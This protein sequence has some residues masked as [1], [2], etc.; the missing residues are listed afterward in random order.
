M[1]ATPRISVI[2][3]CYNEEEGILECHRRLSGALRALSPWYEIV[4]VNDGSRDNTLPLL[5]RLHES[6]PNVTVIELSRNF[7]HQTAVTAGLALAQGEVVVI[8]DADLQDPP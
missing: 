2:V 8:I 1:T 3:P 5:Q 6:D 7:G 4:Y